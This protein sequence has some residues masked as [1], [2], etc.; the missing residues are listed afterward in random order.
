MYWASF[1]LSCSTSSCDLFS[2]ACECIPKTG[3]TT[4]TEQ[5][6]SGAPKPNTPA[7]CCQF[8]S[9]P[10]VVCCRLIPLIALRS[11]SLAACGA[12]HECEGDRP[13]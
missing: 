11:I 10:A 6:V 3:E 12:H 7:G 1:S 5:R 8:P 2:L 4:K 9:L 13:Y